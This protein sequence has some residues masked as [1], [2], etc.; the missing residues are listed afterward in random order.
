MQT[1]PSS[2]REKLFADRDERRICAWLFLAMASLFLLLHEGAITVSDGHSMYETTEA[3]VER[4]AIDVP[5]SAGVPG[6]DGKYY[7]KYGIGLPALSILPY[8]AARP[9]AQ[10]LGGVR[11]ETLEQA[12]VSVT[13]PLI[14]AMLVVAMYLLSRRLRGSVRSS[15]L[16]AI[17]SVA[18]TFLLPYSKDFLSEPL[19][20]LCMVLAIERSIARR[21]G[22]AG[23]ALAYALLTRPQV[24]AF[25]PVLLFVIW[26][27][28]GIAALRRAAVPLTLGCLTMAAWN[29]AR[30]GSATDF[31]YHGEGFTTPFLTGAS[32]LLGSPTKSL[33]LFAPIVALVP[34]ALIR[35]AR[36]DRSTAILITANF[37]ITFVL[38]ATWWSW[39]GG[40]SWGPRL[41]IP[42]L[43]P[44]FAAIAPWIDARAG[45]ARSA[46]VLFVIGAI[47]SAPAMLVSVRAQQTDRGAYAPSIIRQYELVGPTTSYVSDHLYERGNGDHRR[48]LALWQIGAAGVLGHKG[49]IASIGTA[50]MLAMMLAAASR[51]LRASAGGVVIA[52][53]GRLGDLPRAA[54]PA[55]GVA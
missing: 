38:T 6:R 4:G 55:A 39:A 52:F 35:L 17:G 13:I 30:F 12:A 14:T 1:A 34:L 20:A 3:I 11:G 28:D 18:G 31:G 48:Y 46:I 24:L 9:V 15:L 50:F 21:P 7:S 49:F 25:A 23:V 8:V 41:L 51:K 45:R 29:L 27:R 32:G 10:K 33:L 44:A 5:A 47:V 22:A 37:A 42:G 2:A 43:A 16:V 19:T 54:S 36:R 26:R 53:P 40:W